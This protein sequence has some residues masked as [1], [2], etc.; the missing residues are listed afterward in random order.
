MTGPMRQVATA[1]V[2]PKDSFYENL[3][4]VILGLTVGCVT[5]DRLAINFLAPYIMKDLALTNTALG[6]LSSA[7][8]VAWAIAGYTLGKYVDASGRRK[9]FLLASV[10]VFSLSSALSGLASSFATLAAARLVIG[11]SEGPIIPIGQTMMALESSPHRR[12][13]NMG[14]T[15]NFCAAV[16]ACFL[17]PIVLTRVADAHGWRAAFFLTGLPGL[18]LAACIALF[19]RNS[20]PKGEG[21]HSMLAPSGAA[22]VLGT[23]S[24]NL[25]VCGVLAAVMGSWLIVQ[26]AFLPLYLVQVVHFAPAKMGLIMSVVGAGSVVGSLALPALSDRIGRKP[27]MF[28]AG[29]LAVIAPLTVMYLHGSLASL[30]TGLFVGWLSVGCIPIYM[31]TIPAETVS[32]ARIAGSVGLIMGAS[33]IF[34]GT[35][36]PPAA[37]WAGDRFG[38]AAPF[39]IA[40]A[41]AVLLCLLS[42]LLRE[43]A[44]ARA[45]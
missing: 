15:Q 39:W 18:A 38:L 25:W 43:T 40:A 17:G 9:R 14:F 2:G 3:L 23:R 6:L 5:V 45:K 11:F 22:A 26:N 10:I 33:E 30:V 16:L 24:R 42:L 28:V 21:T 4:L 13:F 37:G 29:L 8:S 31:S 20:G 36:A 1:A 32:G 19:L 35:I 7:L 34:G 12:G 41:M 44:P 27:V